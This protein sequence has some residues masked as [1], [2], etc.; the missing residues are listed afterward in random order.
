MASDMRAGQPVPAERERLAA[1]VETVVVAE[2][3]D[4]GGRYHHVHA[5]AI[6]TL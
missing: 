3:D 6:K 1:P 4:T 2:G 5:I